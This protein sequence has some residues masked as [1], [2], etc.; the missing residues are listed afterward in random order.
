MSNQ[1]LLSNAGTLESGFYWN[2]TNL[3]FSFPSSGSFYGQNYGADENIT[4]FAGFS[5]AQQDGIRLALANYSDVANLNFSELTESDTTH[6][7]LRFGLSDRTPTAWAYFPSSVAEGGDSWYNNS[8][9]FFD[10]PEVGTYAYHTFLHEI[11]HTV[12]LQHG[13]EDDELNGA[14]DSKYDSMEYTITTYRSYEGAD[15]NGY[16]N[17]RNGFAQSLMILDIAAIQNVYGANYA[18]N[19]GNT[20]YSFDAQ[21]GE[22]LIDG[23]SQ[24][25]VADNQIFRTL[26]DGNGEDTYNLSNYNTNLQINLGAGEGSLFS[27]DQIANLGD[28]NFAEYNLYNALQV[29]DD[30]RSLIDN[31]V[32]GTGNDSLIGNQISNTLRGGSGNDVLSGLA[33]ND[34]LDGGSGNDIL[35]GGAGL[36]T[37]VFG[38]GTDQVADFIAGEDII[39]FGETNVDDLLIQ[40]F[41]ESDTIIVAQNGNGLIL[42]GID[43]ANVDEDFLGI[44]T[45]ILP[46]TT[47]EIDTVE[48]AVNQLIAPALDV[49]FDDLFSSLLPDSTEA[50]GATGEDL[51]DHVDIAITP[52]FFDL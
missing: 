6:A 52:D 47:I 37:F 28:G 5:T 42:Q 38:S 19:A 20:T 44:G 17:E 50:F 9:G 14:V 12:G 30:T 46:D 34:R 4:N 41:G 2:T 3:T 7:D 26:W 13:H 51:L 11:A 48:E 25:D 40:S 16:S 24:G 31:A 8:A 10:N 22:F 35:I 33:G 23:V 18:T 15:L 29:G 32:G 1:E 39:D 21:T 36:D 49:L 27:D 43:S 45:V